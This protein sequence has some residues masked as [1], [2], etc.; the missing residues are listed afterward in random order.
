MKENVELDELRRAVSLGSNMYLFRK[1]VEWEWE[2]GRMAAFGPN[3]LF[4]MGGATPRV[5]ARAR[6]P[7]F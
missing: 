2:V 7:Y 5:L 4:L 1:E 6:V 3:L